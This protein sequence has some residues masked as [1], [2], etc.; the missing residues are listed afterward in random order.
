MN[1]N[2]GCSEYLYQTIEGAKPKRILQITHSII[3]AVEQYKQDNP[4]VELV[5]I[6]GMVDS[7]SYQINERFDITVIAD[8]LEH[9]T[10]QQGQHLIGN[11]RNRIS[12]Q[13]LMVISQTSLAAK[14]QDADFYSLALIKPK[15]FE[16]LSVYSYQLSGYNHQRTWNNS[17]KWANPQN[18]GKYW[19]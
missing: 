2:A 10:R 13:I 6:K 9:Q 3:P 11:I 17:D 7:N 8:Q 14:W 1:S 5:T 12:N 16:D 4:E 19:W 18:W 15:S